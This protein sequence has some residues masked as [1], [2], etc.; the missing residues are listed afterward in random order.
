MNRFF[1]STPF[2]KILIPLSIGI[3]LG[4]YKDA[5]LWTIV[6]LL[7][8]SLAITVH[9]LLRKRSVV[10]SYRWRTLF[11][12]GIQ[13]CWLTVGVWS[14][15]Q[16]KE[17][18]SFDYP[19]HKQ[20]YEGVIQEVPQKKARSVACKVKL[21]EHDKNIVIYFAV[22]SLSE[23]LCVGDRVM[24]YSQLMPFKNMGN[25]D[26]FDY[27]LHM[28]RKGY[29]AYTYVDTQRWQ[30]TGKESGGVYVSAQ[31][32]RTKV[33]QLFKEMGIEDESFS[34]FSALTI[35][36]V[37][38]LEEDTRK[39]FQATGTSHVLSVSGLHVGIIYQVIVLLLCFL[40]KHNRASQVVRC[41]VVIV[42]LW[43]Y[44]F[45]TGLAPAV[46]RASLMLSLCCLSQMFNKEFFSYNNVCIAAVI[47]LLINPMWLFH[48][49]FQLSFGAVFSILYYMPLL[50][51]I[52]QR[53]KP[54]SLRW[55][56]EAFFISIAV[57]LGT[58]F[59]CLAYFGVFPTYFFITNVLIVPIVFIIMWSAV[60]LLFVTLIGVFW[61]EILPLRQ[62]VV[63][64]LKS[65]VECMMFVVR[66]FESLPYSILSDIYVTP[67]QAV[68]GIVATAC[69]VRF[70]AQGGV[71]LLQ[72][73][74]FLVALFLLTHLFDI[75]K[76]EAEGKSIYIFNR[77]N[78]TEVGA[79]YDKRNLKLS[80]DSVLDETLFL[81]IDTLQIAIPQQ[82]GKKR[83]LQREDKQSPFR[84]DVVLLRGEDSLSVYAISK[85]FD[86]GIV[87]LDGTLSSR[88]A[89]RLSNECK[90]MKIP[91]H[92]V[93][94]MGAYTIKND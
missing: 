79:V 86:I 93:R 61:I 80:R 58:T 41:V 16:F 46:M 64:W 65:L 9:Y 50:E 68:L 18:A 1:A 74:L 26:D 20:V 72:G 49:G 94:Q 40:P 14:V 83:M 89:R 66:F 25:P 92:D 4:S 38:A 78:Y 69:L 42:L 82:T 28:F 7:F 34:V 12:I 10:L 33:L 15:H 47:L 29:S 2:I 62:A 24:F 87:V 75:H 37:D 53:I 11:G 17:R 84:A 8:S 76:K 70:V 45:V 90:K 54:K 48:V 71:K 51:K 21:L 60:P 36:Y 3:Y 13:C 91:Y 85:V 44:A 57:Q 23:R 67:I 88:D 43:G 30:L 5:G 56:S 39:A 55:I 35:G 73:G 22:D 6:L 63:W 19:T 32:F 52:Y 59:L 77:T 31:R 81:K 27:R